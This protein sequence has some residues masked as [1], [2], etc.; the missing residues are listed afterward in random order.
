MAGCY[1]NHLEDR[2]RER[3]LDRYLADEFAPIECGECGHIFETSDIDDDGL[4][5]DC[6]KETALEAKEDEDDEA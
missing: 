1:G 2:A 6:A 5:P 3:Q 4:C